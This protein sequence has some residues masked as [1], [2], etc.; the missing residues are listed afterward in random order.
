MTHPNKI[1]WV[2]PNLLTLMFPI[3]DLL[4]CSPPPTWIP[5]CKFTLA[6]AIFRIEPSAT[7]RSLFFIAIVLDKIFFFFF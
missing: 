6:Y 2:T 3:N 5:S 7:Q 4:T 1:P